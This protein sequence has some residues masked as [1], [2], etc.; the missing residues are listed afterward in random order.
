MPPRASLWLLRKPAAAAAKAR[1]GPAAGEGVVDADG[2]GDAAEAEDETM[3]AVAT[4]AARA[5]WPA[6]L[7]FAFVAKARSSA[8]RCAEAARVEERMTKEKKSREFLQR[9]DCRQK[10]SVFFCFFFSRPSRGCPFQLPVSIFSSP[11]QLDTSK[12]KR[13]NIFNF[14]PKKQCFFILIQISHLPFPL[15]F[16]PRRPSGGGGGGGGAE[17]TRRKHSLLLPPRAWERGSAGGAAGRP[18]RPELQQRPRH[19]LP[20]CGASPASR[21]RRRPPSPPPP[22]PPPPPKVLPLRLQRRRP[23]SCRA[24]RERASKGPARCPWTLDGWLRRGSSAAGRCC[25]CR[26]RTRSSLERR[27]DPKKEV[28]FSFKFLTVSFFIFLLPS[29]S[30]SLVFFTLSLSLSLSDSSSPPPKR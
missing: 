19:S 25:C 21:R 6:Q 26:G 17:P 5:R 7:I 20:I 11:R 13:E 14:N 1:R 16:R 8:E 12:V 28:D 4:P 2:D 30:F 24:R 3:P 23:A 29:S 15:F 27:R 10:K 9:R 22:P 18:R